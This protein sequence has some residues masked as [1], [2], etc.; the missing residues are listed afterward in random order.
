M[1]KKV[2]L[3]LFILSLLASCKQLKEK[4]K[5]TLGLYPLI[6]DG[7]FGYID[8]SCN[9]VINP[10]FDVAWDFSEG[11]AMVEIGEKRTYIDKTGRDICASVNK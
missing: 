4:G 5:T 11:L 9:F 8:R 6:K 2:I 1:G 3:A 10:Q 7:K